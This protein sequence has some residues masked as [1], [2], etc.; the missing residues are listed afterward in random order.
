MKSLHLNMYKRINYITAVLIVLTSIS[1]NAQV[2]TQSPYSRYGLGNVRGSLL[3][4]LRAMGG[5]S[6]G[7][8]TPNGYSNIN[9]QNPASYP[10][11]TH[12]TLDMGLS[13]GFTELKTNSAT[14]KSFNSTLGHLAI[15]FPVVSGKSA[16]SFG[17]L[18]YTQLGYSYTESETLADGNTYK[19]LNSGEGGLTKAY[20]GFGQQ[21]GD[22]FRVGG[23]VEYIFGNLL[24]SR[25]FE[26]QFAP[27]INSRVQNKNSVGGISYSYGAQYSIPLGRRKSITLGYSGSSSSSINSERTYIATRY[28]TDAL[29]EES[30]AL[31]TVS[32]IQGAKSKL[33]LPITHNFGFT[34]QKDNKW[35][36]GADY[37]TGKWSNLIIPGDNDVLQDSWGY[38]LGAQIT[39]DFTSINN[40]FKR[41]E[42]R[43]GFQYDKTYIM[44]QDQDINQ[45]AF[46]FGL[47]LPLAP[48]VTSRTSAYKMNLTAELGRR[49]TLSNSLVQESYF[50][51]HLGFTLNDTWFRRYKFN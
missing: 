12:T 34:Y 11:I 13:G 14:E 37:R 19:Y 43:I 26:P 21:I 38:S 46:T 44:L 15:A 22:H 31:D 8:F 27:S 4:Q 28:L 39:P 1:V 9:M 25:S 47:G 29:G 32:N 30:T 35:M 5:I 41:I 24:E 49:G 36:V 7:V 17:I 48:N 3:P 40:Y 10:G 51:I 42:Y 50:N 20:I 45:R 6:S 2:T 16:V 33:R 18:P 23:N